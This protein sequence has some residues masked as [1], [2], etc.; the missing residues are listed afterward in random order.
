MYNK[1]YPKMK[2]LKLV[3]SILLMIIVF[4]SNAQTPTIEWQN[5]YGGSG[6]DYFLS[7]K[8]TSDGGFVLIGSRDPSNINSQDIS[9]LFVVKLDHN[10]SFEWE[11]CYGGSGMEIGYSILETFDG[12]Y[13]LAG[14]TN[15]N[16][17]DVFGAK[18][19]FD[20]WIVKI[21]SIGNIQWSKCYGGSM[22]DIAYS[23]IQTADGCFVFT[24][25]TASSD[26]DVTSLHPYSE[27][28]IVKIDFIGN[29]IWSKC[30]GGNLYENF[31][32]IKQTNDGG[33]IAVGRTISTDGDVIGTIGNYDDAWIVKLDSV[34]IIEWQK[35]FGGTHYDCA[36][37]I[38]LTSD[39]GYIICGDTRSTDGDID[40][41][42][43]GNFDAWIIKLSNNGNLEWKKILGSGSDDFLNAIQQTTDG[44]FIAV[45]YSHYQPIHYLYDDVWVVKLSQS[46][47]LQWYK[48][49]GGNDDDWGHSIHQTADGG[50]FI[51][52]RSKSSDCD[53]TNNF[54][55]NDGWA[56]KL[57]P[58]YSPVDLY[59]DISEIQI[60][61]NPA[62]DNLTVKVD[63]ALL[64]QPFQIFS[65]TGQLVL[66][67][68][69]TSENPEIHLNSI[70]EG[71]YLLQIGNQSKKIVKIK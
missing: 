6:D 28:W 44:G 19:N 15:S 40:T 30:Y 2:N 65:I 47:T 24:G 70:S 69:L 5:N 22:I 43:G 39:G 20:A 38:N 9:A 26:G 46:G 21:D 10:G 45:G 4:I 1:K 56:L 48:C 50:F 8:V 7:S 31:N 62:Q 64:N 68:K 36:N 23:I 13:L 61:P 27:C 37:D 35:C 3:L 11:K 34:G 29:I 63:P 42:Y 12:G 66:S 54:G 55:A 49:F 17:G 32:S 60:Y 25:E 57:T 41:S 16:D 14:S 58:D 67:G 51:A 59:S 52:G 33:F 18:G 53:L 71:V